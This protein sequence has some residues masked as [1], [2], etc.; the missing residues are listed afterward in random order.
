MLVQ[1]PAE[2][3]RPPALAQTSAA[4]VGATTSGATVKAPAISATDTSAVM[5]GVMVFLGWLKT[6]GRA[7]LH[8]R[9][10][11]DAGSDGPVRRCAGDRK[12]T[13]LHSSHSSISYAVFCL[14]K[15]T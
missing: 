3:W 2:K 8:I 9:L 6:N 12:S 10:S 1:P 11:G 13:R 14:E 4:A 5:R 15:K 7:L